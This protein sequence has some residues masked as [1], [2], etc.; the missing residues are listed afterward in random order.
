MT[1]L[2]HS[3]FIVNGSHKGIFCI[4]LEPVLCS[5]VGSICH[6]I[7]PILVWRAFP[8]PSS[9]VVL[10]VLW[11]GSGLLCVC[12]C[13]IRDRLYLDDTCIYQYTSECIHL[14]QDIYVWIM[15]QRIPWVRSDPATHL[16]ELSDIEQVENSL[17]LIFYSCKI[18]YS[19]TWP[20]SVNW[21]EVLVPSPKAQHKLINCIYWY[22]LWMDCKP[23]TGK[24]V[25]NT[26]I[27]NSALISPF[28]YLISI[29]LVTFTSHAS[30]FVFP[31]FVNK[32]VLHLPSWS[33]SPLGNNF[34]HSW[35]Q[36]ASLI[37]PNS[38]VFD[39]F[40]TIPFL[41]FFLFISDWCLP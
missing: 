22:F 2:A 26:K 1:L 18:G 16:L 9:V 17:C 15:R 35:R 4:I 25:R 12:V 23:L 28:L 30:H 3:K 8:I 32:S 5:K 13:G 39:L 38:P 11:N 29:F 31:L 6:P 41:K 33:Q 20:F 34:Q 36:G 24:W 7:H 21:H 19:L 27:G 40:F 10:E 37:V 14:L